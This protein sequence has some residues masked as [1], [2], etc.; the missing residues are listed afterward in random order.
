MTPSPK[1]K[2]INEKASLRECVSV[3]QHLRVSLPLTQTVSAGGAGGALMGA[4]LAD[5]IGRK[6]A[7][8]IMSAIF[9]VGA[10]LQEVP[11]L[12]AMYAG[13]FLA[14]LAIGATSM[15]SV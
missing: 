15:V 9:M 2:Q 12:S 6:Y 14:G 13:R 5:F 11:I 1:R 3:L 10:A 8:G 7:I 4:P